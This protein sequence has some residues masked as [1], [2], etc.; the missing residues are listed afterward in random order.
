MAVCNKKLMCDLELNTQAETNAWLKQHHPDK[1]RDT[2][3]DVDTFTDVANCYKSRE[4]C[5]GAASLAPL[6]PLTLGAVPLQPPSRE[7]SPHG[8]TL[9]RMET[10]P[11]AARGVVG[12]QPLWGLTGIRSSLAPSRRSASSQ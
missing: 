2:E 5:R 6:T 12:A 11:L 3:M 9:T 8:D 1:G 10:D 7:I 4:F